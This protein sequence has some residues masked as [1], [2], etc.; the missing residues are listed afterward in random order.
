MKLSQISTKDEALTGRSWA[1]LFARVTVGL[2]FFMAGVFKV[3]DLGPLGHARRFF[4]PFQETFL[5]VWSLWIVGTTI[6]V[7]EF[8]AGAILIVGWRVR[9]ACIAL[10]TVLV[11]VTFGHLLDKPIYPFYEHVFP[12]LAL[13]LFILAMPSDTDRFSV[14]AILKWWRARSTDTR[15]KDAPSR[16]PTN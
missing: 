4:L 7:V 2:M 12:R 13:I 5:P 9:T 11:I 6:P 16:A 8:L 3:F 1:V 15:V 10:G 14:D